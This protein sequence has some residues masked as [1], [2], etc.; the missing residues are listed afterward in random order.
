[1]L[2]CTEVYQKSPC[3]ESADD[4]ECHGFPIPDQFLDTVEELQPEYDTIQDIFWATGAAFV[5]RRDLFVQFEGFDADYFAH[6]EEIDLCWR[7]KNAGFAIKVVPESIVY[8][9]GGGTLDYSNPRKVYLNHRN[10]H[11]TILK[12]EQ[13]SKLLW[14]IPIR[15]VTDLASAAKYL[16]E[17]KVKHMTAVISGLAAAYVALPTIIRKRRHVRKINKQYAINK[18][19][20]RGKLEVF[21]LWRYFF[22]GQKT[23]KSITTK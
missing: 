23:F 22:K 17:G 19:D 3:D 8:H 15:F 1:M 21:L 7:L 2:C 20:L 6:Q 5:I 11:W 10:N 14:I 16:V 4:R 13:V 18:P 12:N 9:Q